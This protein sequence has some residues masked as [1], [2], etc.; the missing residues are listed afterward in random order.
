MPGDE[1]GTTVPFKAFEKIEFA[2]IG[3]DPAFT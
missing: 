3:I 2:E 1:A